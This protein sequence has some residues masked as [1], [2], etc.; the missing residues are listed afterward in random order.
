[1][2]KPKEYDE[3]GRGFR[4]P[5]LSIYLIVA[6]IILTGLVYKDYLSLQSGYQHG[7]QARRLLVQRQYDDRLQKDTIE[8]ELMARQLVRIKGIQSAFLAGD[9]QQL[10]DLSM[11]IFTDLNQS[12]RLTHFYYY[13][14]DL[15]T[16]LRVHQPAAYG[17]KNNRVTASQSKA[18]QVTFTGLEIGT[19][20]ALT[21]RS[22]MPW[23]NADGRLLGYIELGKEINHILDEIAQ[24]HQ[25]HLVQTYQKKYFEKDS[26]TDWMRRKE[27][28]VN[29]Q[30]HTSLAILRRA[31]HEALPM[32]EIDHQ[33]ALDANEFE[34]V[35]HDKQYFQVI[36]MPLIDVASRR[37]GALLFLNN[38]TSLQQSFEK[39]LW[40]DL[41]FVSLV[42][43]IGYWPLHITLSKVEGRVL[44]VQKNL[45]QEVVQ[46]TLELEEAK[47]SAEEANMAKSRFL[48]SMS[49]EL[50]TPLNAVLGFSDYMLTDPTGKLTVK[51]REYLES[52]MTA[53]RHLLSLVNDILDLSKIE[54]DNLP[55]T[56]ST[57]S[58]SQ[59]AQ[60]AIEQIRPLAKSRH[61]DIQS[62]CDHPDV[63]VRADFFRFQQVLLNLLSN[64]I[65]YNHEEGA[66]DIFLSQENGFGVVTVKDTG[67]GIALEDVATIFDMFQ[68]VN[69]NPYV[70]A[71]GYGIGLSVTKSLV[72]QM[73]GTISVESRK[74]E[75][76]SFIVRLPLCS[77]D[78]DKELESVIS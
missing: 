77:A 6:I 28:D 48:A 78:V 2:E 25:L 73:S 61:I 35:H 20:G 68:R 65:K 38:V 7:F 32:A 26:F 69:E 27:W 63:L 47:N 67:I 76:S 16:F 33:L 71:D 62:H 60:S 66:V 10:F 3:K 1:M 15:E 53:G 21:L 42:L 8:L 55:L 34:L 75:G 11:P 29:W 52:I 30:E 50:R 18:G 9:R 23:Y 57:V 5:L 44:Q 46:R 22:V 39:E 4:R 54:I 14:T 31:D 19:N 12:I 51:Y 40:L 59:A 36:Q 74:G 13:R 64:A 41:L 37:V 43:S 70:R 24:E 49:H 72:E 58:L 45:E 17:D 56:Y